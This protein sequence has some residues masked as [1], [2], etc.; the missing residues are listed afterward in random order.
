[1]SLSIADDLLTL[2]VLGISYCSIGSLF[3]IGTNSNSAPEFL[4][5]GSCKN[6][7]LFFLLLILSSDY[8][9]SC[10]WLSGNRFLAFK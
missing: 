2:K 7:T 5:G 3:L 10:L 1:M 4:S 8:K 6:C 9:F